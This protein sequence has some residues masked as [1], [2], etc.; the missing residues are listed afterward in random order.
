MPAVGVATWPLVGRDVELEAARRALAGPGDGIVIGGGAGVGK[1]RLAEEALAAVEAGGATI[2]RLVAT[3]AA[4]TIPFGAAA[5]LLGAPGSELADASVSAQRAAATL[6]ATAPLVVGIDDAHLL[7]DATAALLQRIVEVGHVRF[8]VTVRT[9]DPVPDGLRALWES[10]GWPRLELGDLGRDDLRTLLTEALG[11]EVESTTLDRLWAATQGNALFVRELCRDAL[12]A[13][14]LARQHDVWTWSAAPFTGP[15]LHD[16]VADRVGR[17]APDEHALAALLALG[18]PL[19]ADLASSLTSPA[20]V[21]A[22]QARGLVTANGSDDR[23]R[24]RLAHPL[25]AESLRARLGPLEAADLYADLVEAMS[26]DIHRLDADD[27]LRLAVWSVSGNVAVD[28]A[29]LVAA[30]CDARGRDDARLAERL[31]RAALSL[32]HTP[33]GSRDL[34]TPPAPGDRT[35]FAAT[36]ALGQAL[37]DQLRSV[38]AEVVLAPLA[39]RA[40]DD[41]QRAEVALARLAALKLSPDRLDEARRIA[42]TTVVQDPTAR[43]TIRAGLA[44]VLSHAGA[45]R[46]AG[47]IALELLDTADEVVRLHALA[48]ASTWLIHTGRAERALQAAGDL[49][50]VASAHQTDVPRG[51]GWTV[52]AAATALLAIGRACD[53]EAM[54]TATME[55]PAQRRDHARGTLALITGRTALLQGRPATARTALREA[56]LALERSD[57]AGRHGWAVALLAES[58]ALL[59]DG[60]AARATLAGRP[61]TRQSQRYQRDIER[62]S[63]WVMAAE[64]DVTGAIRQ[65]IERADNAAATGQTAF[66]LVFLEVATRLGALG[67]AERAAA[68]A[69]GIDGPLAA[70]LGHLALARAA[71]DGGRLDKTADSLSA[72]GLGLHAAEAAVAAARAHRRAGAATAARASSDKADWLRARCEGARTP[73]LAAT[74]LVDHLT[75]REREVALLAARGLSSR[76]IATRF[77]VS[78]RT[79]DNQLGRAYRKLGITGR[80]D[81][82]AELGSLPAG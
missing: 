82:A 1:T 7:D 4:A 35:A 11:G 20:A 48:P 14:T 34:P 39:D 53:V 59:G 81:L 58:Q 63:L 12:A 72:M 5:P 75:R 23:T 28:P 73:G 64:G 2:V 16:L 31:A 36:V 19:P 60:D 13:G 80:D 62:A 57:T 9:G 70:T 22:L 54:L 78:V 29:V 47:E 79:V 18:E 3:R 21:E 71:G 10:R 43:D 42:A 56:V 55:D 40:G 69:A 41:R 76:E 45:L 6:S 77:A 50:P 15:R 37:G 67:V 68:A 24:L 49:F 8:V 30:A 61:L 17:L 46:E 51:R 52:T 25:Y 26:K 38:E 44:G 27:R 74:E 33:G 66:E 32:P 65:A